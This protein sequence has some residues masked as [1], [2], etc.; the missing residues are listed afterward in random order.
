[1]Y[2]PKDILNNIEKW[3]EK[4]LGPDFQFR[5]YQKETILRTLINILNKRT[6]NTI[7]N[8]PTGSGKSITALIVAG[9]ASEYYQKSS[10]ILVSDTYLHEQYENA[11]NKFKLPYGNIKGQSNNYICEKNGRD[12]AYA[13]CRLNNISFKKLM[14]DK[15]IYKNQSYKCAN[16]CKWILDRKK[17]IL[18]SVTVMTYQFWLFQIHNVEESDFP[19]RDIVIYDECHKI[20]DIVQNM[21]TARFTSLDVENLTACYNLGKIKEY[22]EKDLKD[23]LLSKGIT[24]ISDYKLPELTSNDYRKLVNEYFKSLKDT[25]DKSELCKILK[26]FYDDVINPCISCKEI[27]I[28]D[29]NKILSRGEHLLK[30]DWENLEKM[31]W[32]NHFSCKFEWLFNIID[33]SNLKESGLIKEIN[34]FEY[35]MNSLFSDFEKNLATELSFCSIDESYI[36]WD[37]LLQY[38]KLHNIMMSATIGDIDTYKNN[39]GLFYKDDC[40][41]I[42]DYMQVKSIFDFTKSPINFMPMY[43]MSYK[44]KERSIPE[45]AKYVEM[46]CNYH[47]GQHG[48][49]HTGSF[50][51]TRKFMDTLKDNDV[52]SRISYYDNTKEKRGLIN[53]LSLKDDSIIA[54]PSMIEGVDLPDDLCRFMIILKVPYPSLGSEYVKAKMNYIKTWYQAQT[55]NQIIQCIG[56]GVRNEKDYCS[57]YILD[58][59]FSNIMQQ[60]IKQD[61]NIKNRIKIFSY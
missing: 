9:V 10:Y 6:R 4:W 25:D 3:T 29:I 5:K 32:L 14:D 23:T 26:K 54:G 8:A 21:C 56:R 11:I 30:D 45:L 24:N 40:N 2:N 15:W 16:T 59:C 47:K 31:Q 7:I 19:A 48:L 17:A 49:I 38:S 28:N 42:F 22:T 33:K 12:A 1:M 13:E 37:K 20:P 55:V 43:R 18:S 58:G 34:T 46:I 41:D 60:V 50:E 36:I 53:T 51:I 27:Y 35:K 57:I 61:I 39:L 52:K 44:E